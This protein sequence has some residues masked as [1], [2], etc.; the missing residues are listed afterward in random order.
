MKE[1]EK[2]I[3]PMNSILIKRIITEVAV[4]I[5]IIINATHEV[6]QGADQEKKAEKEVDLND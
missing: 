3:L 1:A 2:E 5:I 4:D 6:D